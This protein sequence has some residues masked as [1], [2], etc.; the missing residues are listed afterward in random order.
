LLTGVLATRAVNPE[1]Q[2]GALFGNVRALGV[3]ALALGVACVY[4]AAMTYGLLLLVNRTLGL[5]VTD[6]DE[7][8]GLDVTQHGEDGYAG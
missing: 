4:S 2:D 5:R 6:S 8:E 7:K 1:G 3:Q